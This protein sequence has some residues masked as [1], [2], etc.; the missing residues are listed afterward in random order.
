MTSSIVIVVVKIEV[1]IEAEDAIMT[2]KYFFAG[3]EV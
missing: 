2:G 3:P 1:E